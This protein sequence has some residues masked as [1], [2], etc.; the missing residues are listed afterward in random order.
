MKALQIYKNIITSSRNSNTYFKGVRYF[1]KQNQKQQSEQYTKFQGQFF[2][3]QE[4]QSRDMEMMT[5]LQML[6]MK[7]VDFKEK[8]IRSQR[9]ANN[10]LTEEE[11]QK[12]R[13]EEEVIKQKV[14]TA[15]KSKTYV[16]L[17]NKGALKLIAK[18]SRDVPKDGLKAISLFEFSDQNAQTVKDKQNV[19]YYKLLVRKYKIHQDTMMSGVQM[20]EDQQEEMTEIN[21]K[22]NELATSGNS[23]AQYTYGKELLSLLRNQSFVNKKEEKQFLQ[24]TYENLNNAANKGVNSAY[25]YLGMMYMDGLYVQK[26]QDKALECYI[27]GAAKNNAYCFFELSRIYSEGQVVDRDPKLQFLYLKRSAEEGFVTAQHLLGI[28]YHEGKITRK[29]DYLALAWFRE[30]IRNGNIISY[31]NAADL[32]FEGGVELKQ[33]RLFALVNYLGA[34]Q[35]GAVFLKERLEQVVKEINEHDK[36]KI[37]EFSFVDLPPEIRQQYQKPSSQI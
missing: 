5:L 27:K 19:E 34:Y 15:E 10:E 23:Q 32:L 2:K 21:Q 14:A 6:N 8:F 33:N 35:N 3:E 4:Q 7:K 22:L 13:D 25:F 17:F 11:L 37:P 1:G 12:L 9:M 30:S 16:N 36:D 18:R 20:N 29:N 31:L 26:D 28:A 24:Y